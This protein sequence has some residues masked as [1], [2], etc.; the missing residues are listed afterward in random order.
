ML[1]SRRTALAYLGASALAAA[2][3]SAH[4]EIATPAETE[5]PFFPV[6][7]NVER[8]ADMTRLAGRAERAAGQAIKMRGRVL[9]LDGRPISSA[10]VEVWQANAAGRYAHPGDSGNTAPLD[11]NFQGYALVETGPDGGFSVT[12][13]KPGAYLVSNLGQRTPH[14]HWMIVA[15]A[16]RLTTQSYFPGEPLNEVD[17]VIRAM[18]EPVRQ[19]IVRAG[20]AG[21]A[22]ALG[23]DWNI[24][25]P[26]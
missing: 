7:T 17:F 24:V 9:G 12:S 14:L 4:D 1:K 23:F 13:I 25:L 18:S 5:G 16:R 8:D 2:C 22:G 19:L 3:A 20:A 21:E 10:R 26:A 11:P 6:D 15:G